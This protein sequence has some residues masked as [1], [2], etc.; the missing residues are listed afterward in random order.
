MPARHKVC[1]AESRVRQVLSRH[2]A[3]AQPGSQHSALSPAC[4]Y[5]T[6]L[7]TGSTQTN[8]SPHPDT[9]M[10]Q[11]ASVFEIITK[12][13]NGRQAL[14]DSVAVITELF[15][16]T[17]WVCRDHQGTVTSGW[18]LMSTC[19]GSRC[20]SSSLK[21]RSASGGACASTASA[22]VLAAAAAASLLRRSRSSC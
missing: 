22:H 11:A 14:H 4:T 2:A 18:L 20:A 21:S 5:H 7:C 13:L 6:H 15:L 17:A 19:S 1:M 16:A 12:M 10:Q 9:I 3:V 8:I